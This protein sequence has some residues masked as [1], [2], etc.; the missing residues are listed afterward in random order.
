MHQ[1][2][3]E[4]FVQL[5]KSLRGRFALWLGFL[6]ICLLSG[7]GITAHQLH[8]INQ[9]E[10]IDQELKQRVVALSASVRARPGFGERP[11]PP[12]YGDRMGPPPP[13]ASPGRPPR[14]G[15]PGPFELHGPPPELREIRLLPETSSLFDESK[16]NGFYFAIW[17]RGGTL[18]KR[19]TNAPPDLPIPDRLDGDTQTHTRMRNDFRESFHFTEMSECVLAG[20]TIKSDLAALRR[21]TAWLVAAGATVLG[22]GLWGA[23]LLVGRAIRPVEDIGATASR[24]S[25][26]N[27]AERISVD[28]TDT[29]LGRLAGV[30]NSTFARLEAAFAQQRHFTA[31][32]SHELRTPLAALISEAQV[33]LARE[34]TAAEYRQAVEACLEIAQQM[35]RLTESLLQLAR[36][37]AGQERMKSEHV[38]LTRLIQARVELVRRSASER[39][40]QIICDLAP[41]ECVGDE[42]RIGQFV[43]NLLTNAIHYNRDGGEVRVTTGTEDG[44]AR[45]T[46]SDTGVGI[47]SEDLRHIFER[48]YRADKSRARAEGRSGLGLAICK[49]IVESHGG[50]IDVS[51]EPGVGSSFIVRLPAAA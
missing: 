43:T 24:I 35:R 40:I 28:E 37:D 9:F 32:A 51:S 6:L 25:A 19:A 17:S 27:L 29:E 14:R 45:L 1:V 49:A 48:F 12:P 38:D 34:R 50:K 5:T 36:F 11:P 44:L 41:A 13:G 20:R 42:E 16:T 33:T 23:W 8:R 10:Q 4:G 7:F 2:H 47:G 30:L 18:L 22:L 31:D 3:G 46:V 15:R 21:F 26:G 39:G